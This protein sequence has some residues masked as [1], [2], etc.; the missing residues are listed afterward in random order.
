M[1]RTATVLLN[2]R[3]IDYDYV[4]DAV[5][6]LGKRLDMALDDFKL[7]I[8]FATQVM[9]YAIEQPD[10]N[11]SDPD[12]TLAVLRNFTSSVNNSTECRFTKRKLIALYPSYWQRRHQ[13]VWSVY[14]QLKY[15]FLRARQLQYD[16]S[17]WWFLTHLKHY[18]YYDPDH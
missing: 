8:A 6:L 16:I 12:Q 7:M 13:T 9:A 18:V 5:T 2:R 10:Y 14:T 11:E 4:I 15:T 1:S 17:Y 3:R